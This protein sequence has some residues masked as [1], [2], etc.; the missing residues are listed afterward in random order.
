MFFDEVMKANWNEIRREGRL[1]F[2]LHVGIRRWA[3]PLGTF[4]WFSFFLVVPI[5][6]QQDAPSWAYLGSR[7][8]WLGLISN[9]LLWPLGGYVWGA[10]QWRRLERQF[11]HSG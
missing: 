6:F 5:F 10:W 8:F 1:H 4:M 7:S 11:V 9:V 2:I 3:L